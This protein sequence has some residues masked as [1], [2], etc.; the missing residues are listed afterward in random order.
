MFNDTDFLFKT[1]GEMIFYCSL[2]RT[3]DIIL[4]I[5]KNENSEH[6]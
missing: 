2:L 6:A 1:Q 5:I 4:F 3:N